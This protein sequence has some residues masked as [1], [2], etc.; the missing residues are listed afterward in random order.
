[1]IYTR[2]GSKVKVLCGDLEKG[3]VDIERVSDRR[4]LRTFICELRAAKGAVEIETAIKKG[5]EVSKMKGE[6]ML[7]KER[8]RQKYLA[9]WRAEVTKRQEKSELE[10]AD[11]LR[12]NKDALD[13]A[14]FEWYENN[15]CHMVN[16][17]H[18]GMTVK[19]CDQDS[20]CIVTM[21]RIVDDAELHLI[22]QYESL[23]TGEELEDETDAYYY[24]KEVL[25]GNITENAEKVKALIED[26]TWFKED[27]D[28]ARD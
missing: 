26:R 16:I 2:F 25:E 23:R 14:G 9:I 22:E 18:K 11:R 21:H 19:V 6:I 17:I 7:S 3:T 13:K 8:V 15:P 10:E 27:S 20:R 4:T 28:E 24:H 5:R 1:M 12:R